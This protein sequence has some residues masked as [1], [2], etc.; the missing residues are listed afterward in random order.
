MVAAPGCGGDDAA[1][2][3]DAGSDALQNDV[4]TSNDT[5][6]GTDT[7][8][9]DTSTPVDAGNAYCDALAAYDLRCGQNDACDQALRN[10]C[11]QDSAILTEG[12]SKAVVECKPID[13]C[14]GDT[15]GGTRR[16]HNDC[17]RGK[18]ATITP[19]AA[20]D[21]LRIDYCARCAPVATATCLADF[22]NPA[23]DSGFSGD[24]LAFLSYTDPVVAEI[25]SLCFATNDAGEA[26]VSSCNGIVGALRVAV[27]LRQAI[28]KHVPPRPLACRTDA[29]DAAGD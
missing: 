20:Q 6:S 8:T 16:A 3:D 28:A 23:S 5:G 2:T 15:D 9:S 17:L 4:T 22:Y 1:I 21:K 25:D 13:A 11:V 18:L 7:S 27:C 24:G 19:T 10:L 14:S 12:G 29:G 26:G